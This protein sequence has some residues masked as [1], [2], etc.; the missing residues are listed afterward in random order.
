[1]FFIAL[2]GVAFAA[3]AVASRFLLSFAG[4]PGKHYAELAVRF[5][6]GGALLTSAPR[7]LFPSAFSVFG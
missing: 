2:G 5:I 3:P 4:S 6:V 1:M 7:M